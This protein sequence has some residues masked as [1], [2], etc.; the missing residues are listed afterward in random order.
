MKSKSINVLSLLVFA[1]LILIPKQVQG[2]EEFKVSSFGLGLQIWFEAEAFDERSP[3]G[4]KHYRVKTQEGAF[5]KVVTPTGTSGGRIR[6]DFDISA[7][8]GKANEWYFWG[9]VHNKDGQS[10]YML[11]R[12]DKGDKVIPDKAPYPG[13]DGAKPFDNLD[14]RVFETNMPRW[15][16]WGEAQGGSIKDLQDGLNT[17]YIFRRQG[18]SSVSWDVFLWC[19]NRKYF[20][21]DAD[22][23]NAKLM[24]ANDFSVGPVEKLSTTWGGIKND[25]RS[26]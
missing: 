13:G 18:N 5:G 16:W 2:V 1:G 24:K 20:P 10:D 4:D 3:E 15:S 8:G 22:Y 6:W 19:S 7:A 12:G 26:E 9:R 25:M 14:D 11:V 21:T 23:Q 17:M